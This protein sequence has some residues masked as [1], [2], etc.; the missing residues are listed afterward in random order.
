MPF[1]KRAVAFAKLWLFPLVLA[2]ALLA[3]GPAGAD[4]R[5][6]NRIVV[7]GD[8]L[9]D[10]GNF[11]ALFGGQAVTPPT[12]GMEGTSNGIPEVVALIPELPYAN[13][14]FSNGPTWIEILASAVGLGSNA[15][16]A[17]T[18]SDGVASNYAVGGATASGTSPI[19]LASQ[20]DAFLRD[21]GGR[22]PSDALY[23]VEFGGND[24]RAALAAGL[25]GGDPSAVIA[26]A[27]G[28]IAHN[29]GRLHFAG[30]R[31]FLVWNAP[32]LGRTPALQRLNDLAV[33]GAAGFAATLSA[34][35][36]HNFPAVLQGLAALPGIEI[37]PFDAGGLLAEV[38]AKPRR[39]G[40]RDVTTACI[41][42]FVAPLFRCAEPDRHFFWDGIHPTRAGHAITAF[43]VGKELVRALARDD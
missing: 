33:P 26:A 14:R 30:A 23:V 28:S 29:I 42:P 2:S 5:P 9:S 35:Y 6:F 24:I 8:S 16:P 38:Q 13:G 22:A 4:G 32:D 17:F 43:L 39:Y 3:P 37:I 40:M 12:Y 27:L 7:F 20:V 25:A 15:R 19:D 1:T 11:H 31:K 34:S 21:V 41:Q 18:G 10:S 36:N